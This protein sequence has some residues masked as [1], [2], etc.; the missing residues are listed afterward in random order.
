MALATPAPSP[1]FTVLDADGKPVAGAKIYTYLT[2]TVTP[3]ATY[4]DGALTIAAANPI[5]ADSAGRF[6][7]YCTPGVSYKW[8]IQAADGSAIRTI[9]PLWTVAVNGVTINDLLFTPDGTYD[10]GK[11]G[12]TRPRDGFFTR[13]LTIGGKLTT[14]GQSF[15]GT[16]AAI[17]G[18]F[19]TAKWSGAAFNGL[20]LDETANT[21]AAYYIIFTQAGVA[22]GSVTRNAATAAVLYNTSSDRRLKRDRGV[23]TDP[24]VLRALV[25]HEFDWLESDTPDRGVFAQEAATVKPLAVSTGTDEQTAAGQWARPW[26]VDYSKFVADLIV[27]W[28]DHERRLVALEQRI[29]N[30]EDTRC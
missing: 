29:R 28:Q 21:A 9:D 3:T 2:G 18:A 20:A 13:D 1:Y 7:V 11:T 23:A 8:V 12:A 17:S 25:V 19:V 22:I 6:L 14:T 15:F 24:A 26:G 27:G 4:T 16:T 5:I 10:I 30:L